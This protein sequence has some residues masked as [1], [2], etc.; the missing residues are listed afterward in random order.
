MSQVRKCAWT[1]ALNN[2]H[3]VL[4]TIH[5][6]CQVWKTKLIMK[7]TDVTFCSMNLR[8]ITL[9]ASSLL[10]RAQ[11]AS[12]EL[13]QNQLLLRSWI[14]LLPLQNKHH[15]LPFTITRIIIFQLFVLLSLSLQWKRLDWPADTQLNNNATCATRYSNRA[16][17]PTFTI[18]ISLLPQN[19]QFS[20]RYRRKEQLSWY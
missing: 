5:S 18:I 3:K 2:I 15:L 19:I 7:Q 13:I 8:A 10:S 12:R 4:T 16:I 9:F 20:L 17:C 1:Y 14:Q 6:T 11:F